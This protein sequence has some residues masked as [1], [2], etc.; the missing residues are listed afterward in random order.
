[1]SSPADAAARVHR[2]PGGEP[3]PLRAST[4][5][6]TGLDCADC[7]TQ[8]RKA[9]AALPGVVEVDLVFATAQL[10]VA[11]QP[12][13]AGEALIRKTIDNL[14]YG[15]R[16]EDLD[17]SS[18]RVEYVLAGLD[19]VECAC[20]VED[21]ILDLPGVRGAS[22]NFGAATLE[23]VLAEDR[24]SRSDIVR[25]VASLGYRAIERRSGR[26]WSFLKTGR[27]AIA[28]A[29]SGLAFGLGVVLGLKVL[30]VVAIAAGGYYMAKAAFAALRTSRG[31]EINFLM[32]V[33]VLGAMLLGR[34]EEAAEVVFLFAAGNAL[35]AST[36]DRTRSELRALLQLTPTSAT[37]REGDREIVRPLSDVCVGAIVL[38]RPGE[39]I[40]VDGEIVEGTS[41]V[42]PSA[43]TGESLPLALSVGDRVLAGAVNG[44]GALVV[45]ATRPAEGSAMARIVKLVEEAQRDRAP[46]QQMVDR[47]SAVYTPAVL[48]LAG[49]LAAGPALLGWSDASRWAYQALALLV[50]SCPCALV[51][52]TPV[53]MAAAIANASRRGLLIKGGSFLEALGR[54]AVVAF[55]KT[56]TL[57][58]GRPAVSEIVAMGDL[59]SQEVLEAAAALESQ[60]EHPFADAI[61]RAWHQGV[62]ERHEVGHEC[63]EEHDPAHDDHDHPAARDVVAI[64]GRGLTGIV[65]GRTL[66]LGNPALMVERG[67]DLGA[68]GPVLERWRDEA[69][70][71]VVLAELET[72]KRGRVLGALALQD[73]VRPEA[74][75]ALADL[76]KAGIRRI[77]ILTGDH[78]AAAERLAGPLGAD[79][80]MPELMPGDK[81]GAIRQLLAEHR[82]VVMVGDGLN[83][84]PALATATV[85]V[86]M[87]ER[88][89]AAALQTA[90]VALMRDDL[91][92]L[93]PAVRLGRQTMAVVA[94][95]IALAVAIK[96]ALLALALGHALTLG[97]AVLGDVGT[98]LLVILNS[99]RLLRS[100]AVP[101]RPI[102][103]PSHSVAS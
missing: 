24:A 91:G 97:V 89:T 47:F 35:A 4:L 101:R 81:V 33:A 67:L 30:F 15:S 54:T 25:A 71:A 82:D 78:R 75:S 66:V 7:A 38:V 100:S 68:L 44:R 37:V 83:D 73:E 5:T 74:A 98:T 63:H 92:L 40:P 56:G 87:G 41:E 52:S 70:S 103:S 43:L 28:T 99:M 96:V 79:L 51:V 48:G 26:G 45:R 31:L 65:H 62:H 46:I 11:Y 90:D 61:T 34:W 32:T 29:V 80:V 6:L 12:E 1:M 36:M 72:P 85:G 58:R 49:V 77:A 39:G 55:D 27:K 10:R 8:I 9:V 69:K 88:G 13:R 53:A 22:V 57:T 17:P 86:A 59:G 50:V 20:V 94:Q 95:N 18:R 21:R 64:L 2:H 93:A 3:R 76:R 84:A 16:A 23:V 14:G 19:C 42:D 102:A 60:S